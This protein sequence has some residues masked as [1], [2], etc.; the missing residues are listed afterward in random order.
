MN[1][2]QQQQPMNQLSSN[3]DAVNNSS[4]LSTMNSSIH[5]LNVNEQGMNMSNPS[6]QQQPQQQQQQQ[7]DPQA[8]NMS[9]TVPMAVYNPITN[10]WNTPGTQMQGGH[11]LQQQQQQQT[12]QS[13][14]S[15]K[16]RM[17]EDNSGASAY[18]GNGGNLA[19][20]A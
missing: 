13:S 2:Q 4:A 9:M 20:C 15:D 7:P 16:N 12:S 17:V 19:P 6:Q 18:G 3:I 14:I 10:A 1:N 8:G 5:S 11:A